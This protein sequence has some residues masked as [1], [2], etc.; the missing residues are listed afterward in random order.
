MQVSEPNQLAVVPPERR[1]ELTVADLKR[2]DD[3]LQQMMR[4]VL[5]PGH[6]Y[7][8]VPG[9]RDAQTGKARLTMLKPGAE[10]ISALFQLVPRF[11]K[12][13]QDLA[14]GHREITITCTLIH[15]GTGNVHATAFGSCSTMESKYRWRVGSLVCPDCEKDAVRKSKQAD[16]GFYCW[17]KIGG[18][19]AEF[20]L[21]DERITT[22][23]VGKSPNPD[24]AD[25]Y[26]TCLKMAAKRAHV[27]AVLIAT[28][29]SDL[30][31]L[32]DVEDEDEDEPAPRKGRKQQQQKPAPETKQDHTPPPLS[33]REQLI[34]DASRA[35]ADLGGDAKKIGEIIASAG[36]APGRRLRELNDDE[37]RKA[38]GALQAE[39]E[40][41][42]GGAK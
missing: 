30:F 37:L 4:E 13:Q 42:K 21:D 10:K 34:V 24:I 23:K 15:L 33:E 38:K 1:G 31:V 2:R 7:G 25:T 39:V 11:E 22:Q 40:L 28:G 9:T 16:K 29:A 6:H 36:V 12:H 20:E 14:D 32:E 27:A 19:G 41:L 26:N 18:C 5:K 17:R 3:L 8:E 35:C